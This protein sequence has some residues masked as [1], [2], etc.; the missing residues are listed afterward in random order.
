M[1]PASRR[2]NSSTSSA[3]ATSAGTTWSIRSQSSIR[4]GSAASR[5]HIA[6]LAARTLMPSPSSTLRRIAGVGDISK[7]ACSSSP[8]RTNSSRER[9]SSVMSVATPATPQTRPY[10]SSRSGNDEL[11]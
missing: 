1:R 4:P 2:A 5:V 7:T 8:C 3:V 9:I 11:L 6:A 10:W